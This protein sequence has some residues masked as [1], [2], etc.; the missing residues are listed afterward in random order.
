MTRRSV[1]LISLIALWL[2]GAACNA[3]TPNENEPDRTVH[4]VVQAR[5]GGPVEEIEMGV[6]EVPVDPPSVSADE[7]PLGDSDLVLGLVIEG[8]PIAYPIR[9]LSAV[10]VLND[11][12]GETS[13]AP[14]W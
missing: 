4:A 14:T 12:V 6:H 7:A 13:L 9:Y 11:R 3:A 5:P 2:L 8:Q 1:P 10:E